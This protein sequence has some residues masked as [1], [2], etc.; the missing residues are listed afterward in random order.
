MNGP[1][2]YEPNGRAKEYAEL[3]CNL[4]RGCDHGCLYCFGP[5][6]LRVSR[7]VF[8]V[9]EL[10]DDLL[11]RLKRDADKHAG[12]PR[13]VM[14]CFTCDPYMKIDTEG[15]TRQAISILHD[16]G[17]KVSILT[18]GGHRARRDFDLLG[19]GDSFGTTLTLARQA[20]SVY[21]E[22]G[23][24]TPAERILTIAV[25]HN[26]GI[27]T[28]VSLEPVIDVEQTLKLLREAAPYVD[29]FKCGRLNHMKSTSNW[30]T[31]ARRLLITLQ[32]YNCGYYIKNDL[33]DLMPPGTPQRREKPVLV[34]A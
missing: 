7:S 33:I 18:K 28:W 21:W 10:K 11:E 15:I 22:P 4:W 9:P 31:Y 19:P 13:P 26:M 23:A 1:V 29:E 6:V 24:A 20:D 8:R 14:L 2:I 12:D 3:A 5:E 17:L 16:S 27:R 32:Q 30:R 25:A 34:K